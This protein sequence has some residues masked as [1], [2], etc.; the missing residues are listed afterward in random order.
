MNPINPMTE[1]HFGRVVVAAA[2][3]AGIAKRVLPPDNATGNFTKVVQGLSVKILL[4]RDQSDLDRLRPGVSVESTVDTG[5]PAPRGE[6]SYMSA[7]EALPTDAQAHPA[8]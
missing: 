5:S 1:R 8:T 6:D 3:E 7:A 2:R 4:D